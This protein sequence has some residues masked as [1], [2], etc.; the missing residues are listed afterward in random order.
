MAVKVGCQFCL[1][2]KQGKILVRQL[3]NDVGYDILYVSANTT[4]VELAYVDGD[5]H[6]SSSSNTTLS[7][8]N[9]P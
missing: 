8:S 3:R 5:L 7:I 6:G 1:V 2:P 9:V 4:I